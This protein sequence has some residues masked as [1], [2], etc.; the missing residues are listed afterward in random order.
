M[1]VD[2]PLLWHIPLSH[3]SE[4]VRW[5]LDFKHVPHRRKGAGG[6]YL[7]K[8]W[9]ATG[10]GTLPILFL[11]GQPIRD[12]TA[13][14]AELEQRYSEPAL[15]PKDELQRR[16]ALELEDYFDEVLGPSVHAAIISPLFQEHPDLALR[17]LTTGMPDAAYRNLRRLG[18]GAPS[19]RPL[20]RA[21]LAM[22]APMSAA[23]STRRARH[24]R[25]EGSRLTG[26]CSASSRRSGSPCPAAGSGCT[27]GGRRWLSASNLRRAVSVPFGL[28]LFLGDQLLK[29]FAKLRICG[30]FKQAVEALQVLPVHELFHGS[31][32][33]Y[34]RLILHRWNRSGNTVRIRGVRSHGGFVTGRFRLC[35][36][37]DARIA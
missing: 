8:A 19:H 26:A 7:I 14:I 21:R 27:A 29:L 1:S 2:L 3:F 9:R 12:S 11:D 16:H 4:K 23:V 28:R 31:S 32:S 5:A 30:P 36:R 18:F 6:D 33:P 35:H 10:H 20:S 17:L 37:G 25:A 34:R 22:R 15:Y 13:I 24:R